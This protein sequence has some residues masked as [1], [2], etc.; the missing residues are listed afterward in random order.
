MLISCKLEA[1]PSIPA[2]A[3]NHDFNIEY[4]NQ[5]KAELKAQITHEVWISFQKL[6]EIDL[7]KKPSHSMGKLKKN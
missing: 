6:Q 3:S 2:I 5:M 1:I 4:F 7:T